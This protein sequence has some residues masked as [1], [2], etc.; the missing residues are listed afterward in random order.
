MTIYLFYIFLGIILYAYL[1]YLLILIILEIFRLLL[2]KKEKDHVEYLPEVTF[3]ITAY[4]EAKYI[5]KKV[6]NT[7]E[8]DYP[9]EKI[10]QTWITDG[11]N[12]KSDEILKKY[13]YITVL[14]ENERKGKIHAMN[15][16]M[17]K[18]KTPIVVFSDANTVLEPDTLRNIVTSFANKKVGCVA[19]EKQIIRLAQARAV[20]TGEGTYWQYESFLK[21]LESNVN[22][23]IGAAGEI[24]A[25]RTELY[26][27][28][29]EDTI[30]DD[31][32]ISLN[33]AK[34][35][36]KI[37]YAPK[38]IA[39]EHASFN[40][41][42]EIKRKTRIACGAIQTMVR[43]PE[44][45]NLFRYGFLSFQYFSHKVLR[46]TI[47]PFAIIG[48]FIL[49]IILV[50]QYGWQHILFGPLL[51]FQIL[52]YQLVLFGLFF[53]NKSIKLKFLFLPFYICVMNYSIIAGMF[54]FLSGNYSVLWEKSKRTDN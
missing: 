16:G 29:K 32:A 15:R 26:R 18:V 39:R 47:V 9:N 35:G 8:L 38:A 43:M 36:Y 2:S 49:N 4:N 53:N 50:G 37:K 12:D 25:I 30:L 17:Q 40:I 45:F 3:F 6:H 14:H 28:V 52:F 33:I 41:Y 51:V 34:R 48:A 13:P 20:G 7:L 22:S 21:R 11:S 44:L 42:E 31:F 5:D 54:R 24:F 27:P 10:K 1:G 23:T 19:G 46:W